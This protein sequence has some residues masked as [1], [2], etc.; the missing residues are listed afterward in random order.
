MRS[1][2]DMESITT[3]ESVSLSEKAT[4]FSIDSLISVEKEKNKDFQEEA[5]LPRKRS[6]E[7]DNEPGC[8]AKRSRSDDGSCEDLAI[9]G[10]EVILEGKELWDRFNELGTEMIITKAGRRM[11]PTLRFSV[12]GADPKASYLVL[13][14]II[15]VD[16]KRY[17]YAY[18][19]STWLVSGKADPPAPTRLC[20]HPDAPFTGEQLMKQPLSFEKVKLTNNEMDEQGHIMLN[21]MHKY[22]PRIH[23]VRK[24]EHI[25]SVINLKSEKTRT[26]AFDE[27]QFIAV[28]AYQNQLIT[29]L[30][31]NS[32][33]FAKGFRD[34]SRLLNP[35]WRERNK[36]FCDQVTR[37]FSYHDQPLSPVLHA[38]TPWRMDPHFRF[39][40][41]PGQ[42]FVDEIC[43]TNH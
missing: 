25:A 21:S 39:P 35:E 7:C 11:F 36:D 12:I 41:D 19:R 14:D 24:R 8:N 40:S 38:P 28:T 30:K 13:M 17:R 2:Q 20:M 15:P 4:A 26:F 29:R 3:A 43:K 22:Q 31:I 37:I 16:D 10:I 18:H 33:P 1:G 32:N 34:S 23:I 5:N 9:D 6:I 42:F 27:T